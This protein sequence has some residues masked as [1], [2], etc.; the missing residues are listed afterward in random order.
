MKQ[1][2]ILRSRLSV[3]ICELKITTD[4]RL[5]PEFSDSPR[6]FARRRGANLA[7]APFAKT[8]YRKDRDGPDCDERLEKITSNI[9]LVRHNAIRLFAERDGDGC[10]R[11]RSIEINP[12]LLLYEAKRHL[13]SEGDLVLSLSILRDQVSGLLADPLDARHIVPGLTQDEE[14]VAYWS[15]VDSELLLPRIQV[16]C[17]H[18]LSHPSTGPAEGV[19]RDRIQLGNNEDDCLIRFKRA[20]WKSV[21]PEGVKTV[22]GVRVRL[23]LKGVKLTSEFRLFGTTTRIPDEEKLA[24]FSEGGV[25]CVHQAM[26]SR[27]EGT[28][29][30]VPP[31][32]R[33]REFGKPITRAKTIA[34]L[35]KL[36]PIPVEVIRDMDEE[37]RQPSDSTRKRL[38]R[39]IAREGNRLKPVPVATLFEPAVYALKQP[40]TTALPSG[41]IDPAIAEV[42]G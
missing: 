22:E 20:R 41:R 6:G 26:M 9:H 13:L 8:D 28:C 35:S 42:Y 11:V 21:G 5:H 15:V 31:E 10:D 40:G 23:V 36:T 29:L 2:A 32:W 12:S 38:K 34:L 24:A 3:S 30:P 39:D 27:L 18:G 16:S 7:D 4:L 25:V 19:K 17:L 1:E 33:D 37:I 14:P